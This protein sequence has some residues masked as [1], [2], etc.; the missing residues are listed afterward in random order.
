MGTPGMATWLSGRVCPSPSPLQRAH[1][2]PE[3][4]AL[5]PAP[6]AASPEQDPRGAQAHQHHLCSHSLLNTGQ[7]VPETA[8]G[9]PGGSPM[10]INHLSEAPCCLPEP[11]SVF[12]THRTTSLPH[13]ARGVPEA[14]GRSKLPKALVWARLSLLGPWA[15][16][17]FSKGKAVPGPWGVPDPQAPVRSRGG[18]GPPKPPDV[19]PSLQGSSGGDSSCFTTRAGAGVGAGPQQKRSLRKRELS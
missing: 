16:P 5:A 1:T 4:A 2:A 15:P 3:T 6:T 7:P 11:G 19:P 10:R 18:P 14:A 12:D 13:P 8:R 9:W 17:S